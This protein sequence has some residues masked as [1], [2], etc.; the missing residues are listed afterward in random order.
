MP[1][2]DKADQIKWARETDKGKKNNRMCNWRNK[3]VNDVNNELYEYYLNCNEC[4]VCGKEF[5]NTKNKILDHDHETGKFRYILCRECNNRDSW[6]Y[7]L[8]IKEY[9]DN[10]YNWNIYYECECGS[11]IKKAE[12]ARHLK[13]KRHNTK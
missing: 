13:T 11:V 3:G 6:K 4:E 2:K 10:R 7:K 12:K 8:G 1:Y 5:E 9:A